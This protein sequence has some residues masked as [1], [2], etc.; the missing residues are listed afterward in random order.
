MKT[1]TSLCVFYFMEKLRHKA[2]TDT[3][4]RWLMTLP[5][6]KNKIGPTAMHLTGTGQNS[7]RKS[8][9]HLSF[10]L[11]GINCDTCPPG[12]GEH[13]RSLPRPQV[14]QSSVPHL[15]KSQGSAHPQDNGWASLWENHLPD[16]GISLSGKY[17]RLRDVTN[18]FPKGISKEKFIDKK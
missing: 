4:D 1:M 6:V 2:T 17:V 16:H 7:K 9:M 14:M 5:W 18:S 11:T 8:I 13:E 3:K 15:G 10:Y 12:R